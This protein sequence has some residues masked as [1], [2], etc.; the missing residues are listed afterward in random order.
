MVL[1]HHHLSLAVYWDSAPTASYLHQCG[2][3]ASAMNACSYACTT[4]CLKS[5]CHQRWLSMST[6]QWWCSRDGVLGS[7]SQDHSQ[8]WLLQTRCLQK[9]GLQGWHVGLDQGHSQKQ[10]LWGSE[11]NWWTEGKVEF[12]SRC[13]SS[14]F[15]EGSRW[16]DSAFGFG[17][18]WEK[19]HKLTL[20]PLLS[21]VTH[22]VS[23]PQ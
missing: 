3:L 1:S 10:F 20:R 7:P 22:S 2:I 21:A 23:T 18:S 8:H 4:Y 15:R 5:I 11:I 14:P 6:G 17:L 13:H 19:G 12:R 16:Q 9:R